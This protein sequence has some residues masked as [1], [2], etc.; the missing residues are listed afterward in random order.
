MAV[1]VPPELLKRFAAFELTEA[2]LARVSAL[3]E[4]AQRDLPGVIAGL[5]AKVAAW[6]EIA[7]ILGHPEVHAFRVSHWQRVICGR[8]DEGFL[9][10]ARTLGS[11]LHRHGLPIFGVALCAVTVINGV[12]AALKLDAGGGLLSRSRD[13][14]RLALARSLSRLS[15]L[16]CELLLETFTTGEAESR[17]SSMRAMATRVEAESDKAVSEISAGM[18]VMAGE[19]TE[20]ARSAAQVAADS[21]AVRDA[22]QQ[23]QVN[24]QAVAEATDQLGLSIREI[25]QQVDGATRATRLAATHGEEGRTRIA[26]L[27]A[28][29]ERI[30]GIARLIADIA[31]QTNLL[32]LNATIEAARAGEAGKG[33]AVVAGEVKSLAAQ[34]AKAT[35]EIS[36]QVQEVSAA[37]GHAVAAVREMADAVSGIDQA[38]AAIAA[39]MEEQSA[40]TQ[41]IARAVGAASEATEAVGGRI[42]V[43]AGLTTDTGHRA[44]RVQDGAEQARASLD[45]LR[46]MLTRVVRESAPEVDRREHPRV[47]GS[48]P[49][50]LESPLLAAP[51]AVTLR[52]LSLG[53]AALV[54]ALPALRQ[55]SRA[56]LHLL[57]VE[58]GLALAVEVVGTSPGLRLGFGTVDPAQERRLQAAIGLLGRRL[59]A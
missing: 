26:T 49:A 59:A 47:A 5:G 51:A 54:E 56:T 21:A 33:F 39:A 44:G 43:V 12:M 3:E 31:A 22:A 15:W 18:D 46:Q 50:R 2:D 20:M 35:E 42:A 7:A 1:V 36:R 16:H 17:A 25:A 28:E 32:A 58:P 10:S 34:T 14:E 19:A 45:V 38:A 52:D 53:G 41:E 37:T 6:P 40:A 4:F 23:A 8:L 9:A 30:G 24:V 11:M 55:G 29:V 13:A 57:E 27:A 48:V